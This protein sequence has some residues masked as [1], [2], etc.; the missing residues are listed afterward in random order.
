MTILQQNIKIL[1]EASGLSQAKYA[2][3]HGITQ[4]VLWTYING[5]AS[6]NLAFIISICKEYGINS[7][8]LMNQKIKIKDGDISNRNYADQRISELRKKAQ[9]LQHELMAVLKEIEWLASGQG[10]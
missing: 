5:A 1:Y 2:K 4:K 10:S 6:P 7:E 8:F 3:K 9:I